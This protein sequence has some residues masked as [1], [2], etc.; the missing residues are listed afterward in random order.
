MSKFTVP[1]NFQED[2]STVPYICQEVPPNVCKQYTA[3]STA[4]SSDT[5]T[6]VYPLSNAFRLVS[7]CIVEKGYVLPNT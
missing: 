3:V 2:R 1:P 7:S 6:N 5:Y 4:E